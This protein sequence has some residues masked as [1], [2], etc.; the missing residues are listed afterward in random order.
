MRAILQLHFAGSMW[1]STPTDVLRYRRLLCGFA[2]A[3]RAGG[4]E[5]RP[6]ADL[7]DSTR[8]PKVRTDLQ[9]PAAQSLSQLR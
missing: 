3:P 8:S 4:V 2:G 6:Y 7:R 1:A 9:V 5:P